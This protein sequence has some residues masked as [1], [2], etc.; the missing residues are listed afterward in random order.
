MMA[1]APH[2]APHSVR[3]SFSD[4]GWVLLLWFRGFAHV[5][6]YS[7]RFPTCRLHRKLFGLVG[8]ADL[9][10]SGLSRAQIGAGLLR[11]HPPA[12]VRFHTDKPSCHR[13]LEVEVLL[14]V[15]L[16]RWQRFVQEHSLKSCLWATTLAIVK[17]IHLGHCTRSLQLKRTE[18]RG[19]VQGQGD[20]LIGVG[21]RHGGRQACDGR[22]INDSPA[23]HDRTLRH[24]CRKHQHGINLK[25]PSFG[26]C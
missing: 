7:R 8:S 24:G 20:S 25:S 23:N 5:G 6:S 3:V 13:V 9:D 19:A 21:Q 18:L 10:V 12:P 14:A 11:E 16:R 17:L 15:K 22:I 1:G 4:R 26:T 2:T